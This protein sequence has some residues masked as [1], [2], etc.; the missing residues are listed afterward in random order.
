MKTRPSNQDLFNKGAG[1][2]FLLFGVANFID[3]I[4][5]LLDKAS[6]KKMNPSE[7]NKPTDETP[8]EKIKSG[9]FLTGSGALLLW[10]DP[11]KRNLA[12][13]PTPDAFQNDKSNFE[14]PRSRL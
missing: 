2:I 5:S 4:G 13:K 7:K 8:K 1:L 14:L 6:Q 9:T 11:E 10:A 3:G 12:K